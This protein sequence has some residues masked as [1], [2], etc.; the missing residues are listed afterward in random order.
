MMNKEGFTIREIE[1]IK[2]I[3]DEHCKNQDFGGDGMCFTHARLV[4]DGD[5][6]G[7]LNSLQEKLGK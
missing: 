3:V 6:W 5:E 4:I 7:A 2:M 1:V